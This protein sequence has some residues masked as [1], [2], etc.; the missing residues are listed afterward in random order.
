MPTTRS[1]AAEEDF[2]FGGGIKPPGYERPFSVQS[3]EKCYKE[4]VEYERN[5]KLSNHGQTVQ[6]SLLTLSQL[7]PA[8]V[9]WCLADLF[10]EEQG[11]DE[12]AE[13]DLRRGLAQPSNNIEQVQASSEFTKKT[14]NELRMFIQTCGNAFPRL[15]NKIQCMQIILIRQRRH[16]ANICKTNSAISTTNMQL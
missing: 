1:N 6:R 10:F 7:L 16:G 9:R 14:K 12:L 3:S 13:S 5:V 8:S 15:T 2:V 4:Y 11:D